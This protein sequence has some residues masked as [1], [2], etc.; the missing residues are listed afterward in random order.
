MSSV[1][2]LNMTV[3]IMAVIFKSDEAHAGTSDFT[4]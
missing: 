4:T 2:C 3:K 1:L